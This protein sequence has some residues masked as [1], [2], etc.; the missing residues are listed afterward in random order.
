[1]VWPLVCGFLLYHQN[2]LTAQTGSKFHLNL[3]ILI[4]LGIELLLKVH[5]THIEL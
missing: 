4:Q 5:V 1:M 2:S 3:K